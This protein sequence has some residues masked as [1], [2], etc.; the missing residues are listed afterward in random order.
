[1]PLPPVS[2][3]PWLV[4]ADT[5]RESHGARVCQSARLEGFEGTVIRR[6]LFPDAVPAPSA[7][8]PTQANR[9]QSFTSETVELL[10]AATGQL[11]KIQRSGMHDG[12]INISA[13]QSEARIVDNEYSRLASA[14][15]PNVRPQVRE[16]ARC[17]L[18]RFSTGFGLD[19]RKVVAGPERARLQQKLV[20]EV[21]RAIR[22]SLAVMLARADYADAV[23][24]LA[25]QRVT[26]VVPADN[27]GELLHDMQ[28]DSGRMPVVADNFYDNPL[29]GTYVITVGAV[30]PTPESPDRSDLSVS[31]YSSPTDQISIYA[32]GT[33][34]LE[35]G[36]SFAAPRVAAVAAELH[37]VLGQA[38][39]K[40]VADF[41][42][43]HLTRDLHYQSTVVRV[44]DAEKAGALLRIQERKI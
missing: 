30:G 39:N 16:R 4:I 42:K 43:T 24:E 21:H 26:V 31:Y 44:L 23:R 18:H 14:W 13:G 34:G 27:Q 7:A 20:D 29:S 36:T 2:A 33:S 32:L 8:Y 17:E 40:E 19:E 28:L 37:K 22:T 10:R 5:F 25:E 38:T 15:D 41:I 1:M 3:R 9:S 12:A 11:R 35:E 6:D